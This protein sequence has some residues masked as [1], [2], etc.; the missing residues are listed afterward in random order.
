MSIHLIETSYET[1]TKVIPQMKT[2]QEVANITGISYHRIRLLCLN[3][4]IQYI[5]A[6]NKFLINLDRFIDYLNGE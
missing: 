1:S 2:I 3:N 6:G 4:E 5:K